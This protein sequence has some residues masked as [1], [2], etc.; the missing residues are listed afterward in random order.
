[1]IYTLG[2]TGITLAQLQALLD[3]HQA[4]LVNIRYRPS[5]RNP[6]F[7]Q[8]ALQG[9]LGSRYVHVGALGNR[10]Y[11]GGPI[12]IVDLDAGIATVGSFP[13][14]RPSHCCASAPT[15]TGVTARAWPKRSDRRWDARSSMSSSRPLRAASC[16]WSCE[17]RRRHGRR[18]CFRSSVSARRPPASAVRQA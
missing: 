5:S 17:R 14:Q 18:A 1:M 8:H 4:I 7:R 13:D 10:N 3:A 11:Q 6:S 15:S 9:R 2:Y 12:A 16:R